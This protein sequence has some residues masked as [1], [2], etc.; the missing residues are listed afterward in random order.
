MF[1]IFGNKNLSKTNIIFNVPLTKTVSFPSF[2]FTFKNVAVNNVQGERVNWLNPGFPTRLKV[3]QA[4]SPAVL[5]ESVHPPR[6]MCA[7]SQITL[8]HLKG[9]HQ[10]WFISEKNNYMK[11]N[12][13]YFF[14][15]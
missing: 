9:E 3:D 12:Q 2:I 13:I 5:G 7:L 1:T 11:R 10:L 14:F 6:P 4:S 15:N 8:L